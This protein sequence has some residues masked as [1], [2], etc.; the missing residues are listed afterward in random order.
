[1]CGGISM[2]ITGQLVTQQ[3]DTVVPVL[4]FISPVLPPDGNFYILYVLIYGEDSGFDN[5]SLLIAIKSDNIHTCLY[6][7]VSL[8][9]IFEVW[10]DCG[11]LTTADDNV[12]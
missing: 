10:V 4:H 11:I 9:C 7:A 1:M 12:I 2:G 8:Y 5:L 6:L 3:P